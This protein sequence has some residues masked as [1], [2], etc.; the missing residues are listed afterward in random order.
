MYF[1]FCVGIVHTNY[2]TELVEFLPE[3]K[4]QDYLILHST[5]E[6]DDRNDIRS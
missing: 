6:V 1:V 5:H 2:T 3:F 4:I